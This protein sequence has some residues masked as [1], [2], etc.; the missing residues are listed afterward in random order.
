MKEKKTR[1][2]TSY[3]ILG[4]LTIL[5]T[6]FAFLTPSLIEDMKEEY[7]EKIMANLVKIYTQAETVDKLEGGLHNDSD[8]AGRYKILSQKAGIEVFNSPTKRKYSLIKDYQTGKITVYYGEKQLQYPEFKEEQIPTVG[9]I[10]NEDLFLFSESTGKVVLLGFS[11][12]AS[13]N[14]NSNSTIEIPSHYNGKPVVEIADKAF[15][16]QNLGGSVVIPETVKAV[17]RYSFANNGPKSDS[18]NIGKPYA[19][20]WKLEKDKWVKVN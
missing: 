1:K 17:G 2:T 12:L 11:S 3:L 4:F 14:L 7:R 10:K 13:R 15:Y 8:N 20:T 5:M 18:G 9:D 16:G 6:C 19:G